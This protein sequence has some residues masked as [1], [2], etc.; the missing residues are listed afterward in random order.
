M[1]PTLSP[2]PA[3]VTPRQPR[4]SSRTLDIFPSASAVITLFRTELKLHNSDNVVKGGRASTF[5]RADERAPESGAH[6]DAR[7]EECGRL[8]KVPVGFDLMLG[9]RRQA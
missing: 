6:H 7:R 4:T 2:P 1:R 9:G 5:P 8:C 3:S